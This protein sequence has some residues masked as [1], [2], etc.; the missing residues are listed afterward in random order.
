MNK[1]LKFLNKLSVKERKSTE[2]DIKLIVARNLETLD[3]K[4]L[5]GFNNLFRSKRGKVR[6]IFLMEGDKT[7]IIK[8]SRRNDNTYNI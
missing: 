8:I 3:V 2:E 7:H 4:K 5:A 1:I 6:I